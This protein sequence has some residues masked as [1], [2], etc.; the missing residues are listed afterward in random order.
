[1]VIHFSSGNTKLFQFYCDCLFC[2]LNGKTCKFLGIHKLATLAKIILLLKCM[3]RYVCTVND[4]NHINV[5]HL[6]ILEV[7]LVMA[8]NRHNSTCSIACKYEITD[9][10]RYFL[11]IYRIDR[12]QALQHTS[13][14]RLVQFCT[15]HIIFL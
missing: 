6:G 15:I 3:L 1:M 13:R 7:T 12:I 9:K 2:F 11:A 4:L 8:R 10:K 14:L 5:M